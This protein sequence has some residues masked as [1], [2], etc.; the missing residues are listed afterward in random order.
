MLKSKKISHYE[1]MRIK[2]INNITLKRN[3]EKKE[4]E[5]KYT[6]YTFKLSNVLYFASK[7]LKID[8]LYYYLILLSKW[9]LLINEKGPKV[10][11]EE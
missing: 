2:M 3:A 9:I 5:G 1:M 6:C 10:F 11:I 8:I 4:R 7:L